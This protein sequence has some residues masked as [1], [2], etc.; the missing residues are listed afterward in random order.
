MAYNGQCEI[1]IQ[2]GERWLINLKKGGNGDFLLSYGKALSMADEHKKAITILE[3]AKNYYPNTI[4]YTALGDSY[5]E[6]GKIDKAET[7]YLQAW[8]MIPSR[9]YPKYL[10][11]KL[12]YDTG[13]NDKAMEVAGEL[14]KKEVKI[15]STAIM[16]IKEEMKNII[17]PIE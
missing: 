2:P 12:Y 13:Q 5:K 15:Q 10:L 4:L 3:Y 11:A 1:L 14:L 8:Y 6:L 7:S 9:F 17:E 16:E